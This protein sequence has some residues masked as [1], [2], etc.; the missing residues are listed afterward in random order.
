MNKKQKILCLIAIFIVVGM[1]A[2]PPFNLHG[3]GGRVISLGHAWAFAPPDYG[4]VDTALLIAQWVGTVIVCG[5][6]FLLLWDD[7]RTHS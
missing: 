4:I 3:P 7:P 2:Y 1:G 6:A 5:I